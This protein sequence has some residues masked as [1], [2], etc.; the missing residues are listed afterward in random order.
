MTKD[1]KNIN[2]KSTIRRRVNKVKV[3]KAYSHE[4]ES[5]FNSALIEIDKEVE[6]KNIP[7][8]DQ[9]FSFPA[10]VRKIKDRDFNYIETETIEEFLMVIMYSYEDD[11]QDS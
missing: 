6:Y 1:S 9:V 5:K 8:V 7:K 11:N 10:S 3:F 4:M 2:I